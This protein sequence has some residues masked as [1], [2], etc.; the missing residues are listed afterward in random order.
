M[1][2]LSLCVSTPGIASIFLPEIWITA[3]LRLSSTDTLADATYEIESGKV[4]VT[5]KM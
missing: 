3:V 5:F 4:R 2:L 1:S